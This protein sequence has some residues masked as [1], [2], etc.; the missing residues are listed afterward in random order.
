MVNKV[1][2]QE[3]R[4]KENSNDDS[5]FYSQPRFVHHLDN[6]FRR[7]LTTLYKEIIPK[8]SI[9]LDLMSS[10]VSHLPPE[11]NYKK[12][13]GHG[14][15]KKELQKNSRLDYYWVQDLNKNQKLP[16]KDWSVD[17]CLMV[18]AWQYLQEPEA[19]A[20]EIKRIVKP[21]GS[22]II[23][24][25]NR[26]FWEKAPRIWREGGD[27]EHIKYIKAILLSQGWDKVR[28][29]E[30]SD[31]KE[32]IFGMVGIKTDPFLSVIGSY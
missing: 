29:I 6:N 10:W 5:I 24:F 8:N 15:N 1:L 14:M 4:E 16:L 26:A 23:S 9:I 2:F 22:V 18:A 17:F 19:V 3:Q 20:S 7:R 12:V 13:I 11:I 27:K 32:G 28:S 25:S 30:E 31:N 21:G